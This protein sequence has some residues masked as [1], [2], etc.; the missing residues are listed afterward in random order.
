MKPFTKKQIEAH[1]KKELKT[2]LSFIEENAIKKIQKALNSGCISENSDFMQKNCLLALTVLEDAAY[3]FRI[4]S[5]YRPEAEN[6][7]KFI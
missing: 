7:Q 3:Q 5:D 2:L 4:K 1:T 6:I